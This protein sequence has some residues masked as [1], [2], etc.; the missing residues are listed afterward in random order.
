MPTTP[1]VQQSVGNTFQNANY[2]IVDNRFYS[3]GPLA[4]ALI[5]DNNGASTNIS[6][7]VQ[8]G[9]G[10]QLNFSPITADGQLRTD[11]FADVQLGGQWFM[12][13][14]PNLGWW[15]IGAIDE[16]GGIERKSSVKHDD[17]M[18]LQSLFAYDT[19]MT[20]KGKTIAFSGIE[21]FKPV[22]MRLKMNLPLATPAGV[23]LVEDPGQPNY[24]LSQ[25]VEPYDV[26]YQIML[27]FAR[28]RPGGYI[29]SV[30]GYPLVKQT[31]VGSEKRSKT[32]ADAASPF[33][34]TAMPDAFHTN[35]DP[36]NPTSPTVVPAF[37]TQWIGG[38]SWSAMFEQGS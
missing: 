12:N 22:M 10:P 29:Y 17:Q 20:G 24:S 32:D 31:D 25:P 2:G 3:R 26:N 34:F 33:T 11:L 7:Y 19:D 15:R 27:V 5:R 8:G 13:T 35:I 16:K 28:P 14:A 18:I 6:H 30:E 1:P 23:N 21:A 38:G 36:T 4:C 37:W 9:S